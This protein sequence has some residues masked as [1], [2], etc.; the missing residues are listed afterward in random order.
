MKGF[1]SPSIPKWY[2]MLQESSR[3]AQDLAKRFHICRSKGTGYYANCNLTYCSIISCGE[4]D[5]TDWRLGLKESIQFNNRSRNAIEALKSVSVISESSGFRCI[6][7]VSRIM[8]FS[9]AR[10][11]VNSL[12]C[13]GTLGCNSGHG[14]HVSAAS[15]L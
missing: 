3:S 5:V 7:A 11:T 6:A 1:K 9:C 10:A 8:I 14:A 2:Q 4:A 15:P 12:V 13:A